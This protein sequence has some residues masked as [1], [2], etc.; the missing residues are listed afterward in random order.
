MY[1]TAGC[2]DCRRA[3]ALFEQHHVPFTYKGVDTDPT[4]DEEFRALIGSGDRSVPRILFRLGADAE[5]MAVKHTLV[6]PSNNDLLR[7]LRVRH[8][9]TSG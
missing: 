5:H 3:K 4:A 8:W 1:G 9:I 7:E 6:E 2:G